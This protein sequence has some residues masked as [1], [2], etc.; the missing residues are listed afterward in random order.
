ML[1]MTRRYCTAKRESVETASCFF[2]YL[3]KNADA[4]N[5]IPSPTR[6]VDKTGMPVF[7]MFLCVV[8]YLDIPVINHMY[9]EPR[10]S[11]MKLP[12]QKKVKRTIFMIHRERLR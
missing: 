1:Y 5:G 6:M 4:R 10:H 12:L 2:N 3:Q 7:A 9:F 8:Q 11:Q